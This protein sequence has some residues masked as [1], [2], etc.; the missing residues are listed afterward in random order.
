MIHRLTYRCLSQQ[1]DGEKPGFSA[2]SQLLQFEV[3]MNHIDTHSV[4]D[5][6]QDD[7]KNGQF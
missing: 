3:K 5:A 2:S 7:S 6:P 4:S 1:Y